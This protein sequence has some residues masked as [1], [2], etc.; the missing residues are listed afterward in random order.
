MALTLKEVGPD[1][2]EAVVPTS[3]I[4][5]ENPVVGVEKVVAKPRT[6]AVAKAYLEV[7]SSAE[8][9]ELAAKY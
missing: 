3:S 1:Q 6:A 9:Q 5:A 2:V 7:L 8:A 4:L